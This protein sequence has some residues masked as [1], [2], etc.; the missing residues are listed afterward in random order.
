MPEPAPE[1][2]SLHLPWRQRWVSARVLPCGVW[3]VRYSCVLPHCSGPGARSSRRAL[4]LLSWTGSRSAGKFQVPGSLGFPLPSYTLNPAFA[5]LRGMQGKSVLCTR[6]H[7]LAVFGDEGPDFWL[8][9]CFL[10]NKL[11]HVG[12][13]LLCKACWFS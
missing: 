6:R 3:Q 2:G 9:S 4:T 10:L 7:R 5:W 8:L 1:P 13:M 11:E 12:K